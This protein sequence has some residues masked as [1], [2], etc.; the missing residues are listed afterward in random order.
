MATI[1]GTT[2]NDTLTSAA[3]S[4]I[5]NGYGGND[6][7]YGNA[8]NDNLYGGDGNDG[9]F[10][11]TENDL[12]QGGAGSDIME[13]GDGIDTLDYSTSTAAVLVHMGTGVTEGGHAAGDTFSGIEI[14]NG[15]AYNDTLTGDAS[16][17][18][19][20]GLAG[21]DILNGNVGADTLYGGLGNDHLYIDNI[22]DVVSEVGGGGTDTVFSTVNHTLGAD[23][24][25]LTL[26]GT[27][28]VNGTGNAGNNILTGNDGGGVFTGD[29]HLMGLG[30]NDT[31]YGGMGIDTLDG[32]TGN[33]LMAGGKMND[34][35]IVD[36]ATDQVIEYANEGNDDLVMASINY[37]LYDPVTS[38]HI[39]NVTLTGT[40]NLYAIGNNQANILTG[41]SG[42]NALTGDEADDTLRGNE[43][44]D[45]LYGG[46]GNDSMI[47]G[48]GDDV[49]WIDSVDDEVEESIGMG[50]DTVFTT[51]NNYGLESHFENLEFAL[52]V[53]N[54]AGNNLNNIITANAQNNLL[55]GE[56]GN[57]TLFGFAGNDTLDGGT[58]SDSMVGGAG[59]DLYM[60]DT[61]GDVAV[62]GDGAGGYDRIHARADHTMS[63]GIEEVLV[64]H[65]TSVDIIGNDLGNLMTGGTGANLL[66]GMAGN[67][68]IYGGGGTDTLIG[69]AGNNQLHGGAGNDT[70]IVENVTDL[71]VELAAGGTDTVEVA[72]TY[73]L[74]AEFENLT[75]LGTGNNNG[76]GNAANNEILGNAGNN[77]LFG[78]AGNDTIE[79]GAGNDT[80]NGGTGNDSMEGGT[81]DDYYVVDSVNDR[82]TE[83]NNAG[84][85]TVET[86]INYTLGSYVE[87]LIL[88]G[89]GDLAGT[90][91]SMANH[92]TGNAG[93]NLLS[94][95]SGNDTLIGGAG[96]DTLD[97]GAYHDHMTGGTGDDTYMV[98]SAND[99]IIELAGEGTDTVVSEYSYTLME[100]FENL[101]LDG[102]SG[103]SGTGTNGA[104]VLT[105]NSG[106]NML[107]GLDGNDTLYG[108]GGA[109]T[110]NGGLG[111]DSMVGGVGND[112]YIID[113]VGDVA[114]EL[115]GGGTDTLNT[116]F[117]TTLSSVFENLILSGTANL[118]GTGNA[119]DNV[120]TGN[121]G[122]NLL[123]GS[124][125]NDTLIGGAGND[126]L[127]GGA[128]TDSMVG[129]AGDDIYYVS[130]SSDVIVEGTNAGI[131]LVYAA[132][133]YIMKANIENLIQVGSA[134]INVLGNSMANHLTGNSGNN[135]LT[136]G[137]GADTILGGAGDDTLDGGSG[138][139]VMTGGT[140]NDTYYANAAGDQI[141]EAADEGID[142]VIASTHWTLVSTVENLTFASTG[143]Y[144]GTGNAADNVMIGNS[145]RNEL[146]G[147]VGN[148]TL[149]GGTGN[150]TLTGGEGADQFVFSTS[151]AGNDTITDYNT[152]D[153]GAEEGDMLVFTGLLVG[154]FAYMGDAAFTGGTD[155]SE[156]RFD[157]ATGR[158]QIDSD[159]NGTADF[160]L[161]LTG[162]T[163][164]TQLDATDFLWS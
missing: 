56:S 2:G 158:L 15:S 131:D 116:I 5:L 121:A 58:G 62:E 20:Y 124:T 96:N 8:G 4:D 142:T 65:T 145:G 148:D 161:T 162:M 77:S 32:G 51:V 37:T 27:L 21:N 48:A 159:G 55:E 88:A 100:N 16:A 90:G 127:D 47:G 95:E 44:N 107:N 98:G 67:D 80:L 81:G 14:L 84:F 64:T 136:G 122:D 11:G 40:A 163:T 82:V 83:S 36:S 123:A 29:N 46:T 109:D 140:G 103:L 72:A 26:I 25:N 30:G 63:A 28:S 39:E 9:L 41:N 22:D 143:G 52:S 119:L 130:T 139:D 128:H 105:G 94:G 60:V 152:L 149:N 74:A 92:I 156:A 120:L 23:F 66:N 157:S 24:E 129:G 155:N 147:M 38:N 108:G 17:N 111:N 141:Y 132:Y 102:T 118:N 106:A 91:N 69:G 59:D 71:L 34:I 76:S 18:V 164:A 43:G 68:T 70:Y 137:S 151:T 53:M 78:W 160:V 135:V 93:H 54:G 138:N 133:S 85:E 61:V 115:E 150:D 75:L 35:Y 10:G 49:Y 114:I 146:S 13:G 33:D 87:N 125:G 1:N 45:S 3:N 79:A 73:F 104:N 12:L 110:L 97:G 50:T 153:G 144:R 89:T 57:D 117:T 112:T 126:I 31:L 19:L 154:S 7:L 113:A 42:D 134:S 6:L 101:V 86:W 99:I